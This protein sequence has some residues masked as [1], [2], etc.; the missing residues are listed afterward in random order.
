MNPPNI[1]KL[2]DEQAYKDYY[3]ENFCNKCP[4]YT[5]DKIPVMFYPEKFEHSFYKRSKASWNAPKSSFDYLRAERMEWI[6]DILQN[7]LITPKKGYDKA[8][9]SYDNKRRVA[10]L[11]KENYLVVIEIDKK[12]KGI[13]ITA[14]LVDNEYA[15]EKIRKSPNWEK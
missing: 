14:Y 9:G 3:I 5:F 7:P 12:G 11:D 1:L 10:F 4:I 13:F 6:R 2:S 15:A 8:K